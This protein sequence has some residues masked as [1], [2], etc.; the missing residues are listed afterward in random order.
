MIQARKSLLL[1]AGAMFVGLCSFSQ[2][3]P[4]GN[5][6]AKPD[7]T[8]KAPPT[9][10]KPTVAEKVKSS[11]KMDGLFT[12]YQD[13]A[14][15]SVQIY[16]KKNQ[17]GKE[18]IYQSF[19]MGGPTALFLNQNMIRQTWVFKIQKAFDKLEFSQVNTNFYYDKSN[20]VSKAANVDVTE[21]IFY[22]DK[23]T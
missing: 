2:N 21:A 11:K 12:V 13:T 8:K 20:A 4:A 9:P 10:P 18:Y 17:L 15:G 1:L 16:V 5:A 22:A 19:S 23:V 7:T 3:N 14:N 6:A